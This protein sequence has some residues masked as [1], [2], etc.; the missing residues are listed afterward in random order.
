MWVD[1]LITFGMLSI[2]FFISNIIV[3]LGFLFSTVY[4]LSYT[5]RFYEGRPKPK[6]WTFIITGLGVFCISELV[7]L[8]MTYRI[9]V[10]DLE[11]MIALI[12]QNFAIIM[13]TIGAYMLFREVS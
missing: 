3:P 12:L 9:G 6:S 5:L 7:Q 11:A 8:T 2:P 4:A 1:P 10:G 13:I